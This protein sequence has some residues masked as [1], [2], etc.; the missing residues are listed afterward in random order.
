MDSTAGVAQ[1]AG[2]K[3]LTCSTCRAE[4]PLADLAQREE[5]REELTEVYLIC[6]S[7]GTRTHVY[8]DTPELS[9]ERLALR[10]IGLEWQATRSPALWQKY[11]TART[12]YNRHFDALQRRWQ[13]KLKV[14]QVQKEPGAND[15]GRQ[16]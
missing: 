15:G 16:D 14:A 13:R 3:V 9:G 6:P 10:K 5:L 2:A 4:H 12:V 11:Q 1:A 8:F 7:C